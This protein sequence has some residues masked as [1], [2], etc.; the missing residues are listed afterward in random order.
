M[1]IP[2]EDKPLEALREETMDRLIV[3]YG[4]GKLSMEAFQRRLDQAFEARDHETLI[5]LGAD[6]DVEVDPGY[7][8]RKEESLGHV[9]ETGEPEDVDTI[10]SILSG[11]NRSGEWLVPKVLR[12]VTVLG[13]VD[14]DFTNARLSGRT[15][16]IK[17]FCLLGG[18]DI[19]VPEG[20]NTTVKA[21]C[22]LGGVDNSA[23]HTGDPA[24]PQ[25]VVE[26]FVLLGGVDVKLKRT[27]RER[28]LAFA[29]GVRA[30]FN[31]LDA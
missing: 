16:R 4:H 3:S 24:A 2:H 1:P 27:L 25:L 28:V 8:E 12:V 10:V 26:G 9:F 19:G 14:L 7:L 15:T 20:I 11:N 31:R 17:V 5:A 23:P 29:D 6:L 21:S 30:M 22:F 18:V 13:G